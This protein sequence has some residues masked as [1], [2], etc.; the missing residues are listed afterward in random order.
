MISFYLHGRWEIVF[1]LLLNSFF[2]YEKN[3]LF[4]QCVEVTA[5]EVTPI[6]P[7]K[8]K[9]EQIDSDKL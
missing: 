8:L 7:M 2:A 9:F 6:K 4:G 1:E 5:I 3:C